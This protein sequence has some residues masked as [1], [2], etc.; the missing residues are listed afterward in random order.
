MKNMQITIIAILAMVLL[1]LSQKK[2]VVKKPTIPEIKTVDT[3]KVPTHTDV[4]CNI[5]AFTKAEAE[6][7]FKNGL[8][9]LKQS[10]GLTKNEAEKLEQQY[11]LETAHFKSGQFKK[12][13][14]AGMEKFGN[15]FPYGWNS[16]NNYFWKEHRDLKPCGYHT[17]PENKTGISKSYL[18][19]PSLYA[20][21]AT[22][23][24]NAR[25][26]GGNFAAW[27]S[28]NKDSQKRYFD[29]LNSIIPRITRTI[30]W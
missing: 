28:N 16:L 22:M 30:Q 12:T 25:M 21:M 13:Y 3:P 11:R 8:I 29:K 27:Y 4:P 20:A 10:F 15:S 26:K 23:L 24:H 19:F 6:N 9:K 18:K 17:M 5:P 14:S 2:K 1:F 7:M